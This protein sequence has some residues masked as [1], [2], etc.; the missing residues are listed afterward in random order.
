MLGI[1]L[2]I[3]IMVGLLSGRIGAVLLEDTGFGMV[4]DLVLGVLGAL[5]GGWLLPKFGVQFGGEISSAFITAT[6]GALA[7]LV[8]V[9]LVRG[10]EFWRGSPGSSV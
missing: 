6:L 1:I 3:F 9:R 8:L 5:L 10:G 4:G 2:S 7:L